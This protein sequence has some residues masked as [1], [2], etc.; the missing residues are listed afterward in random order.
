[1][2]PLDRRRSAAAGH[3]ACDRNRAARSAGAPRGGD[4]P[5]H[6][7][8]ARRRPG[9]HE[10]RRLRHAGAVVWAGRGC[11]GVHHGPGSPNAAAGRHACVG[12][13]RGRRRPRREPGRG[14]G[15]DRGPG[16]GIH[17]GR[18][19]AHRLARPPSPGPARHCGSGCTG[20]R[21]GRGERGPDLCAH[22][23]GPSRDRSDP[24]ARVRAPVARVPELGDRVH[25]NSHEPRDCGRGLRVRD[26]R[27]PARDRH[28]SARHRAPTVRRRVGPVVLLRA[29]VRA[30][31]GLPAVPARP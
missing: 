15:T 6:A 8:R 18:R 20:R 5:R 17:P 23:P 19:F 24:S 1:M 25:V 2:G 27:V 31:D 10:P 22:R 30:L 21:A 3:S 28:R 11:A 12:T 9:P 7:R 4:P 13:T 26:G 14:I 29:A 16:D